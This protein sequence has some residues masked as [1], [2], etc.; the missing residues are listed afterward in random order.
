[1]DALQIGFGALGA[2]IGGTLGVLLLISLRKNAVARGFGV[3]QLIGLALAGGSF[4]AMV[5]E[6]HFGPQMRAEQATDAGR[7]IDA[8]FRDE[9]LFVAIA[10]VDREAAQTMRTEVEVAYRAGGSAAATRRSV[11]LGEALGRRAV[12]EYGPR[13]SDEALRG[14]YAAVLRWGGSM[15]GRPDAC[16]SA[17]YREIA[18]VPMN[19]MEVGAIAD[20][21]ATE[22]VQA[23]MAEIIRSASEDTIDFDL[24]VA[25]AAQDEAGAQLLEVYETND[26]RFLLGAVPQDASEMQLACDVMLSTM[27]IVLAHPQAPAVFRLW[28]AQSG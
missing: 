25:L 23:A 22:N 10:E 9:P 27:E 12:S 3:I 1:M 21:R 24:E 6:P 8:L 19:S 17:M 18:A 2:V 15:Q 7:D 4:G 5:L 20:A 11:E 14:L 16:Y 26:L 13:A 28:L